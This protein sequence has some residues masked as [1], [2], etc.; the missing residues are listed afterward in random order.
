MTTLLAGRGAPRST[1]AETPWE[2]A[3]RTLADLVGRELT[4]SGPDTTAEPDPSTPPDVWIA[5]L[6]I[7]DELSV[8]AGDRPPPGTVPVFLYGHHALVGPMPSATGTAPACAGCLA[9]RWQSVRSS[10]LRDALELGGETCAVGQ[11]PYPT[12]FV[13]DTLAALI[14]AHRAGSGAAAAPHLAEIY[15]VDL[16]TLRI[17]RL[18]LAPDAECPDCGRCVPDSSAGASLRLLAAPKPEPRTFRVRDVDDYGLDLAA[19]AN[20][21]CGALSAAALPDLTSTSTAA[22][23]GSFTLRSGRYLRE[24]LFGGH[25]DTYAHSGMVAVLEGLERAAGLRA[26]G[27]TADRI[28]SLRSLGADALDPRVCGMYSDALYRDNPHLTQFTPDTEIKWVWGHSLR[29]DR[30]ILVPEVLAYYHTVPAESRFVQETSNGCASGS[31]LAEAIYFGLMEAVERD[32]FLLAWYGRAPLPE[33]DPSTSSRPAT[34][35]MVDRLAMYGYRARFFDNRITFTVP[36]VTAVAVRQRPGLGT[37]AFGAGASLDPEAAMSAALSEI[38]TDAVK[39]EMRSRDAEARLRPMV[40]DYR[41]VIGLHDH[42]LLYGLPEMARH[43]D[44]LLGGATVPVALAE[45]FGRVRPGPELSTD[46][47]TDLEHCVAEIAAAGFDVIV[48]DQ[49]MPE[50]LDLGL[51]TVKVIVPGLI[52]IDFGV[53]RQRAPLMPRMRTALRASGHRDHDLRP[54][55]FNPA[56]HPFP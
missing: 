53:K 54:D 44:F 41:K 9:R 38:A 6:G 20:P 50:E 42:P 33:I 12:P 11:S 39:I 28:A 49:T 24:T 48:V 36:V 35:Q 30:P 19:F 14:R 32:A 37:L 18:P 55:E 8:A 22:V 15:H 51:R 5:P 25:A 56:P 45:R 21:I 3:C 46:L 40:E 27:R 4:R 34:R 23:L 43:A 52:P 1:A 16:E 47:L 13:A 26:R 7:R 17:R 29:D 10:S 2:S 31:C